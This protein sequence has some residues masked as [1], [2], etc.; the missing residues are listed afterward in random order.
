MI[1]GAAFFDSATS[2]AMI[3]GG[4][5]DLTILGAMEVSEQRR[6]RQLDDPRQ[7]GQGHGRRHGPGQRRAARHGHDGAHQQGRPAP[8][9]SACALPLTGV[10]CVH[11]I[12]TELCVFEVRDGGLA[13]VEL[14]PDVTLEEVQQ[15][16]EAAFTVAL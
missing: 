15:K 16:T 8:R 9:S 14:A 1:P 4:H 3:R 6:P 10:A 12:F 11:K 2:F 13:L 7:D 5:I